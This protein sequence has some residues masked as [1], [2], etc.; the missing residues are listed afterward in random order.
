[1]AGKRVL[2]LSAAIGEG[3]D[4]PARE[5]AAGLHLEAPGT[6][7]AIVD[8]LRAMGRF[9]HW[10]TVRGS[11]FHSR[12]GNVVFDAEFWLLTHWDPTRRFVGRGLEVLGGRRLRRL[13]ARARPDVVVSTYPGLTETLGRLRARGRLDVPV[14]AAITD[15]AALRWWSHPSVDLHLVTHPESDAEVREIAGSDAEV[16]A[17]TGFSSPVFLRPPRREDARARLGLPEGGAVVVVSGGGWAVGDLAGA[18]AAAL[19]AG[20]DTVV[21]LCGRNEDVRGRLAARFA[22]DARVRP[23]GFTDRMADVL[24]SA[25]ALVH[26]TAGLTVLEALVLGCPTISYGW[27]RAHIRANNAAFARHGL[28]EVAR[29]PAELRDALRRALGTRA[30]PYPS[31]ASWPTAAGVLRDRFLTAA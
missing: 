13:I 1:M 20:A 14:V 25:D 21:V 26:S 29:T 11:P 31:W 18:T 22:G 6:E 17:V 2:I 7:V 16:V 10:A 28:A 23:L 3:H 8:G 9:L 12:I 27:G 30:D 15:L 19:Q 5:L 24:S 4:G